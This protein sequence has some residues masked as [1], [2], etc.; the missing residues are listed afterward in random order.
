MQYISVFNFKEKKQKQ[1][2]YNLYL[3]MQKTTIGLW[4][5]TKLS[6]PHNAIIIVAVTIDKTHTHTHTHTVIQ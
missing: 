6:A 5:L 2:I 4:E 3:H 1:S